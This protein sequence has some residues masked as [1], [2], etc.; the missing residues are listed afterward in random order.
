MTVMPLKWVLGVTIMFKD[1]SLRIPIEKKVALVKGSGSGK[2]T[3]VALLQRF[4]DPLGGVAIYKLQLKWL[5][6]QMGLV[7][8]KNSYFLPPPLKITYFSAR[9]TQPWKKW[10]LWPRLLMLIILFVSCLMVMILRWGRKEF[11]CP[12]YINRE[13]PLHEQ[14]SKPHKCSF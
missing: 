13:S 8:P 3:V 2:S 1:F 6:S 4:Y 9:K 7:S 11:K 5:R 14:S 10:L 12:E